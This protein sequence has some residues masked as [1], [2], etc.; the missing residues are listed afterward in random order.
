MITAYTIAM[1]V[2]NTA[3]DPFV[4]VI[5]VE[6]WCSFDNEV[7]WECNYTTHYECLTYNEICKEK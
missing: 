7:G 1:F 5:G 2:V 6:K 3:L 4:P